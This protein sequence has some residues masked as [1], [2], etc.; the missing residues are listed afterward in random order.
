MDI[1]TFLLKIKE[2][3]EVSADLC[4]QTSLEDND[5]FDSLSLMVISSWIKEEFNLDIK[6]NTL[7]ETK[8][9]GTLYNNI[10]I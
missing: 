3:T 7:L 5:I 1:N 6:V 10:F 2:I 9:L 4:I 8:D